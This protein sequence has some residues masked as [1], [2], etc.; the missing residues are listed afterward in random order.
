MQQTCSQ[1]GF[2]SPVPAKFCR[3][4]G[5]AMFAE[6]ESSEAATRN[7]GRQTPAPAPETPPTS[8]PFTSPTPQA[9]PSMADAFA[10]NTARLHNQP[11][12]PYSQPQVPMGMPPVYPAYP[13][14]AAKSNWWKWLLGIALTTLLVCGGLLG[15]A[16]MRANEKFHQIQAEMNPPGQGVPD[17][18][19]GGVPV[20]PLPPPPPPA[21]G[22]GMAP[23]FEQLTYPNAKVT[24]RVNAFGQQVMEMKT[25]DNLAQVKAFYEKQMGA[26]VVESEGG[27]GDKSLVFQKTPLMV[28]VGDDKKE[29]GQLSITIIRSGWIPQI[30]QPGKP[31]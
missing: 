26:P 10:P 17:G 15:Y 28:T 19:P 27:D 3:Q 31:K 23:E 14:P 6:S 2:V 21:P 12:T 4:C 8:H 22:K 5:A 9:P 16:F 24:S 13:P 18:I 1:C 29:A 25:T 30:N 11:Q 7:Y 20:P